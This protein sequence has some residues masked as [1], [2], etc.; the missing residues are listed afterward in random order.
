MMNAFWASVNFDAFIAVCPPSSQTNHTAKTLIPN[1]GVLRGQIR[2]ARP[3][4]AIGATT[5]R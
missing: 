4:G 5:E 1:E 2:I 3:A